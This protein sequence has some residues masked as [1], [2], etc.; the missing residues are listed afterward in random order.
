MQ[1]FKQ[2]VSQL[3]LQDFVFELKRRE[4]AVVNAFNLLTVIVLKGGEV[5]KKLRHKAE[6]HL[7][8]FIGSIKAGKSA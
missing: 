1:W 6:T 7:L 3:A 8:V 4:V 5:L 2:L